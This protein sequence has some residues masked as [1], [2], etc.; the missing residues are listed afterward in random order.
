[1]DGFFKVSNLKYLSQ[2]SFLK[3]IF[4]YFLVFR[5]LN[6]FTLK[7]HN[8]YKNRKSNIQI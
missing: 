7:I 4:I 5:L 1:M 6:I 8:I 2:L 3:F